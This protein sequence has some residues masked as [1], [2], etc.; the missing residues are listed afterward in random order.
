[1]RGDCGRL[2][3]D[4]SLQ[5]L[6]I[7]QEQNE[8]HANQDRSSDETLGLDVVLNQPPDQQDDC[9]QKQNGADHGIQTLQLVDGQIEEVQK[10]E[11]D[12]DD[13][14]HKVQTGSKAQTSFAEARAASVPLVAEQRADNDAD[15]DLEDLDDSTVG[16]QVASVESS[17]CVHSESGVNEELE[18]LK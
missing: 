15:D 4:L 12:V 14:D 8:Q 11:N 17:H 1:M 6:Q 18:K 3:G 13:Q 10:E 7:V 16:G 9:D 2:V 5:D